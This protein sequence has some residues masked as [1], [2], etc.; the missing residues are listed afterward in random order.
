MEEFDGFFDFGDFSGLPARKISGFEAAR[1]V[2]VFG[3]ALRVGRFGVRSSSGL[4]ETLELFSE[5]GDDFFDQACFFF[6]ETYSGKARSSAEVHGALRS[7]ICLR[8]FA[9]CS[10]VTGPDLLLHA[11]RM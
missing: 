9:T 4:G 8:T 2:F 6:I 11:L 1:V 10:T 5:G 3:F 7:A